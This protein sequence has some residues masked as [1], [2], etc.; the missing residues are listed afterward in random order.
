[1]EPDTPLPAGAGKIAPDT[2]NAWFERNR[3]RIL[4]D[5]FRLLRFPSVSAD[6]AR[7]GDCRACADWL[8]GHL[9]ALGLGSEL[10]ETSGNPVVYGAT[11]P[12]D[13]PRI[14][15]YG[16]YDVQPADSPETWRSPPFEPELRHG[17]VYA[18]GAQDNKG[19]LLYFLQA[20]ACLRDLGAATPNLRILLDGE[21]ECSSPGLTAGLNGWRRRLG[22]DVLMVCDTC[23]DARTGR[24]ALI[25]GLRGILHFEAILRGA[26]HD[27]HSGMHGGLA[28]NP[29]HAMSRMLASLHDRHGRIRVPG[30]LDNLRPANEREQALLNKFPLDAAEYRRRT[31]AP[32]LGGERR[33]PPAERLGFRPTIE[34][35]GIAGGYSGEGIKTIVPSECRAKLSARLCPDQDPERCLAAVKRR[36]ARRRPPGTT[37]AFENEAI[38]GPGFRLTTGSPIFR[39]AGE[40]LRRVD[41]RGAVIR[42]EGASIPVVSALR[43][44]SGAAPLLTGFG[45][46]EDRIH[47]PNESFALEAFRKGL[48]Y[49]VL[50]LN[51]LGGGE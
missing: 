25:A 18:R 2:V 26:R 28:P 17:R 29:I 36:L 42:W 21:E 12:G 50:M 31:G 8:R 9:E 4:A 6:P 19:Q 10:L 35:N 32:P 7:R 1:M 51:T 20:L 47:G 23:A 44:I 3:E 48:L 14:L 22:A 38:G 24:P 39:A 11:R 27:L 41:P 46:D 13:G 33:R 49:S 45:S 5:W 43:D 16:H 37:L 40:V 30:F 34:V 15:F